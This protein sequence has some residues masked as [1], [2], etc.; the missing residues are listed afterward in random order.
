ML[1]S[2]RNYQGIKECNL[3][4]GKIN[5]LFGL[6]GVGKSSFINAILA[7]MTGQIKKDDFRMNS[8]LCTIEIKTDNTHLQVTGKE[9]GNTFKTRA[10]TLTKTAFIN[11][12]W[13]DKD[14]KILF[15][16]KFVE[17]P[18]KEQVSILFDLID[19]KI[20]IESLNETIKQ[21]LQKIGA[22]TTDFDM[23][24]Y[25]SEIGNSEVSATPDTFDFAEQAL[26]NERK[27]L[28]KE[29]D[30][31]R[32][33]TDASSWTR[34][35]EAELQRLK[36]NTT[37]DTEM[38]KKITAAGEI[39]EEIAAIESSNKTY[40]KEEDLASIV[41]EGELDREN[42]NL[43]LGKFKK[44]FGDIDIEKIPEIKK[45]KEGLKKRREEMAAS[46][47]KH[48]GNVYNIKQQIKHLQVVLNSKDKS[49][50]EFCPKKLNCPFGTSKEMQ[51]DV[52]AR[53]KEMELEIESEQKLALQIGEERKVI[54]DRLAEIEVL[55]NRVNLMKEDQVKIAGLEKAVSI[56]KEY[57]RKAVTKND[58]RSKIL[59]ANAKTL[60]GLK[61]RLKLIEKEL[62]VVSDQDHNRIKELDDKF[63]QNKHI[64]DEIKKS[65]EK[66]ARRERLFMDIQ[67]ISNVLSV[68]PKVKDNAIRVPVMQFL[69]A[70]NP[71]F[72]KNLSAKLLFQDGS[73]WYQDSSTPESGVPLEK[74]SSGQRFL[75]GVIL[76]HA[77]NM[78]LGNRFVFLV[79]GV[80]IIDQEKRKPF[81]KIIGELSQKYATT[82]ITCTMNSGKTID[83]IRATVP[84]I[85]SCFHV[86][87]GGVFE[88]F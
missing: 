38:Q 6:I 42:L 9:S 85:V 37:F 50:V 67:K 8:D 43:A 23:S 78:I 69:D 81:N 84:S 32:F 2:I 59:A 70:V 77:F 86:K 19:V 79:D 30:E 71:L 62:P 66:I 7:I 51:D 53:I 40:E 58:A 31:I 49:G 61:T 54:V 72:D 18:F 21:E 44:D 11:Q 80:D 26:S 41:K 46:H 47:G 29:V 65:P 60:D 13:G 82:V 15:V 87:S 22:T 55:L 39:R 14:P 63:A 56:R 48:D 83:E 88:C 33:T 76:Q 10:G 57:Y 24:K 3:T 45:E 1:V 16:K 34:E 5:Y 4:L 25:L 35:D 28:K 64:L 68:M 20:S 73:L 74:A 36:Q 75:S 27:L 17:K 12:L 52:N